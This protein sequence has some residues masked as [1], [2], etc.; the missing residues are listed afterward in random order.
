M[1]APLYFLSVFLLHGHMFETG[2]SKTRASSFLFCYMV[3]VQSH[4]FIR[5]KTA[6]TRPRKLRDIIGHTHVLCS[7]LLASSLLPSTSSP[8]ILHIFYIHCHLHQLSIQ[9]QPSSPQDAT[10]GGTS[11]S[12]FLPQF[13]MRQSCILPKSSH[14]RARSAYEGPA[15]CW[16]VEI[17]SG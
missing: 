15:G 2:T 17:A 1:K 8:S 11:S 16:A 10:S 5:F 7:F 4:P 9:I 6:P 14:C 12:T 13:P 3:V